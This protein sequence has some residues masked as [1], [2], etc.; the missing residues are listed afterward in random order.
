[1]AIIELSGI[2]R[3]LFK[4]TQKRVERW[5]RR[6]GSARVVQKLSFLVAASL[7]EKGF[8]TA[9]SVV[10]CVV[11][12][13]P[14]TF[15]LKKSSVVDNQEVFLVLGQALFEMASKLG[16]FL[17]TLGDRSEVI[18]FWWPEVE[19]TPLPEA[20]P[21]FVAWALACRNWKIRTILFLLPQRI[22]PKE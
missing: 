21:I 2:L 18:S 17:L 20:Y 19:I 13:C 6:G 4:L 8:P 11:K 16:A 22:N 3:T 10:W 9:N 7:D 12:G 5:T 14:H 1:M 15:L